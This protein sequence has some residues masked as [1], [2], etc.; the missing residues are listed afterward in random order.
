MPSVGGCLDDRCLDSGIC[1]GRCL[2]NSRNLD[3]FIANGCLSVGRFLG[4]CL[5]NSKYLQ[6]RCL[7]MVDA[8]MVV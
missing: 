4:R 1:I 3:R 7:T 6:G 5:G 8:S 2:G